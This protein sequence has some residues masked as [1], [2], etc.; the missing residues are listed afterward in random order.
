M[1]AQQLFAR[2]QSEEGARLLPRRRASRWRSRRWMRWA[3]PTARRVPWPRIRSAGC[4]SSSSTTAPACPSRWRS[5]EYL[6]DLHPDP[7]MTGREPPRARP[8]A[9]HGAHLRDRRASPT[10]PRSS[11][12]HRRLFRPAGEAVRRGRRRT[13]G[14]GVGVK[15]EGWPPL[16]A[17]SGRTC[18]SAAPG[19][20]SPTARCSRRSS[21]PS[22][23]ASDRPA[24][25]PT[26]SAG[27]RRLQGT[28]ERQRLSNHGF[29][30]SA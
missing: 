28:A 16:T 19:R 14:R 8:G 2:A 1:Q 9:R 5:S 29:H 21:S 23:P 15:P 18:S 12:T 22:S 4:R 20:R 6:E 25:P 30:G 10:R 17:S 24:A 11:R 13:A 26:R 7:P 27:T 3:A